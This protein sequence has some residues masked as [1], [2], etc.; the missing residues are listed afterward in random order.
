VHMDLAAAYLSHASSTLPAGATAQ[1]VR[2]IA[3][4]LMSD[5]K[6]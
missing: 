5:A 3:R 6:S 1:G 2:T 4:V